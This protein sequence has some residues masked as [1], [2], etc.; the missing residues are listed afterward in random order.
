MQFLIE[1]LPAHKNIGKL[2]EEI[3]FLE[4]MIDNLL[5]SDRLSI[6]YSILDLHKIQISEIINKIMNLFPSMK[7]KIHIHNSIPNEEII[8]DETKFIIALRN[9]LDNAIKYSENKIVELSIEKNAGVKFYVKD[10]GIGI[11]DEN[12]INIT[13]PFFQADKSISTRGFGLGLT[14]C[15]KIIESHKGRLSIQSDI[16]KGSVFILHLPPIKS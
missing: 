13:K 12:I 2:R 6:P 14:I 11:S 4:S 5:L 7:E 10:S 15:K 1:L 8:V 3:N 16:G 9:L